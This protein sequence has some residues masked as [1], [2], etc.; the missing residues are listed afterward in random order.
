MCTYG[1]HIGNEKDAFYD[2]L[3]EF[4]ARTGNQRE[5]TMGGMKARTRKRPNDC[6]I[7]NYGE[8][9]ANDNGNKL[10]NLCK[11]FS[12]R[13]LNGFFPLKN[14]QSGHQ[15]SKVNHRL[16]YDKTETRFRIQDIRI[17]RGLEC[18]SDH[19]LF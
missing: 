6:L 4:S 19:Y 9:V 1:R 7:R 14:I 13:I 3:E 11:Q 8:H 18:G 5:I 2:Q 12:L 17:Y 15:T 16:H 10:I